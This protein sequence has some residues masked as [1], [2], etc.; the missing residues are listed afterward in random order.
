MQRKNLPYIYISYMGFS[1]QWGCS[2]AA[3]PP[4][5][6]P[7]LC[8][9]SAA[10]W[11]RYARAAE[12]NPSRGVPPD[13][14]PPFAHKGHPPK[15]CG[16]AS[17]SSQLLRADALFVSDSIARQWCSLVPRCTPLRRCNLRLVAMN[18][19]LEFSPAYEWLKWIGKPSTRERVCAVQGGHR[20]VLLPSFRWW[21]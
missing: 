18:R 1:P 2:V 19:R 11:P 13:P 12:G 20:A 3:P 21:I 9:R 5:V 14:L 8:R 4:P 15:G 6:H 7:W 17:L 16:F 10:Q